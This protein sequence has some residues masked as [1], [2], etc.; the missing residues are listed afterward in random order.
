MAPRNLQNT[1]SYKLPSDG[2]QKR[3]D[4]P[5][6]ARDSSNTS[7]RKGDREDGVPSVPGGWLSRRSGILDSLAS[8][9]RNADGVP[10]SMHPPTPSPT[11]AGH[12]TTSRT[13]ASSYPSTS[14]TAIL[15]L[16][17]QR[18]RSSSFRMIAD[19]TSTAF[20][21]S[22]SSQQPPT[23]QVVQSPEPHPWKVEQGGIARSEACR[24]CQ[25]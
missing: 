10:S 3:R 20:T 18:D 16:N 17:R 13:P 5:C 25:R 23:H 2:S 8:R 21:P 15:P 14:A 6:H 12:P 1:H 22:A 9:C 19:T 7:S 24:I 4:A 11:P